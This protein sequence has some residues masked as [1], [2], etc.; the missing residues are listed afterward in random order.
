MVVRVDEGFVEPDVELGVVV[1][2]VAA[3][4]VVSVGSETKYNHFMNGSKETLKQT[5]LPINVLLHNVNRKLYT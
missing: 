3:V 1:G 5:Y 2:V 4:L